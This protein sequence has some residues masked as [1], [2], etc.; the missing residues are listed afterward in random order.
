MQLNS[1]RVQCSFYDK[2]TGEWA[3]GIFYVVPHALFSGKQRE[4]KACV[5]ELDKRIITSINRKHFA[6]FNLHRLNTLDMLGV[7]LYKRIF[8]HLSNLNQK[9]TRK[10]KLKFEKDYEDVCRELLGLPVQPEASVAAASS[11]VSSVI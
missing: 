1:T 5:I 2:E 9:N 7:V 6:F 8:F 10:D 3:S 11:V 4:L